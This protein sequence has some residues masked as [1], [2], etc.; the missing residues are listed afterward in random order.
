MQKTAKAT[1]DLAETPR[2][3]RSRHAA[4]PHGDRTVLTRG[5]LLAQVCFFAQAREEGALARLRRQP[6]ALRVTT[7][8][9][10]AG[11]SEAR[12]DVADS[13]DTQVLRGII[14]QQF[15]ALKDILPQCALAC[16][17]GAAPGRICACRRQELRVTRPE[18]RRAGAQSTSPTR[19]RWS[20]ATR[21]PCCLLSRAADG[22][23]LISD[24]G[25]QQIACGTVATACTVLARLRSVVYV[26][27]VGECIVTGLSA[28]AEEQTKHGGRHHLWCSGARR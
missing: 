24:C 18:P 16:N 1:S 2:S 21:S 8:R 28:P 6:A 7:S 15:P 13:T 14:I 10:A 5:G 11:T 25:H 17:G 20:P 27:S 12:V 23:V 22:R 9:L 26:Y 3:C 19:A 4:L